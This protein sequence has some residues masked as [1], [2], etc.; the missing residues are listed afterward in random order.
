VRQGLEE[1]TDDGIRRFAIAVADAE[2]PAQARDADH[3]GAAGSGGALEIGAERLRGGEQ[4]VRVD[5]PVERGEV[6][7]RRRRAAGLRDLGA[8][9]RGLPH[10][11]RWDDEERAVHAH[12]G[13][14][15]ARPRRPAR[16]PR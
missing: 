11:L 13:A 8:D 16:P 14:R 3:G 15:P 5:G 6:H 4:R 2:R 9:A 10:R 1:P 12:R 7:V